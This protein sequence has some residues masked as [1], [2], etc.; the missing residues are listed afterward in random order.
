VEE[1]PDEEPLVRG[2]VLDDRVGALLI[3]NDEYQST[4]KRGQ[5]DPL[6]PQIVK[7]C[8]EQKPLQ[9]QHMKDDA[10]RDI[11][12]GRATKS[13]STCPSTR[14][15][16]DRPIPQQSFDWYFNPRMP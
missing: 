15:L 13:S 2:G 12:S 5:V 14:I 10:T 8:A 1:V 11:N 9:A 3:L 6:E 16:Q 4:L 7:K